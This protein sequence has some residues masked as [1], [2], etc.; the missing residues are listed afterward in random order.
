M[1]SFSFTNALASRIPHTKQVTEPQRSMQIM[2]V[3]PAPANDSNQHETRSELNVG[4]SSSGSDA[5][6][7]CVDSARK[8]ARNCTQSAGGLDSTRSSREDRV[9]LSTATIAN[10]NLA[11]DVDT[12]GP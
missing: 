3:E 11:D 10:L 4:A 6:A 7:A 5:A 8:K 2:Q 12:M 9:W 1:L